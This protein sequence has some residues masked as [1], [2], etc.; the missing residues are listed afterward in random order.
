M[1]KTILPAV[2]ALF[3][4]LVAGFLSSL[5]SEHHRRFRDKQA[6]AG[7]F[8]GEL[9]SYKEGWPMFAKQFPLLFEMAKSGE[10][11][12]IPKID[13]P[14]DRVFESCVG[15]IGMLGPELAEDLAYVY[16]NLNAFRTTFI[17]VSSDGTTPR[18]QLAMLESAWACLNRAQARGEDLPD[19]LKAYAKRRYVLQVL[20][21]LFAGFVGLAMLVGAYSAGAL[22]ARGGTQPST[23]VQADN[24]T[25]SFCDIANHTLK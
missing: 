19:R 20:P 24:P 13:K 6:L 16:N 23:P 14:T 15:Q 17:L 11:V 18:Q 21:L 5:L 7:A 25:S 8:A 2:L 4:T 22:I 1:D 12:N 3:G 9:G 10:K